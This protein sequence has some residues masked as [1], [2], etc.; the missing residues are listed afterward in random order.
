[1]SD[2][3]IVITIFVFQGWLWWVVLP[4]LFLTCVA[5]LADMAKSW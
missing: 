4:I 2:D 3:L 5:I 1:M